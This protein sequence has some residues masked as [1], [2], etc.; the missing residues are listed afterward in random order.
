MLGE[1][2]SVLTIEV[3]IVIIMFFSVNNAFVTPEYR[4]NKKVAKNIFF[5][6]I[7]QIG[8]GLPSLLTKKGCMR[9]F[10]RMNP[11]RKH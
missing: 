7:S 4:S 3:V 5:A 1:K 8:K 10:K 11:N 6:D 2:T 9:F